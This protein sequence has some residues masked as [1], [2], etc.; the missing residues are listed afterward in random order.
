M[1]QKTNQQQIN[2]KNGQNGQKKRKFMLTLLTSACTSIITTAAFSTSAVASTLQSQLFTIP[3]DAK[4]TE[5]LLDS[6]WKNRENIKNQQTIIDYLQTKPTVP[7]N[8]NIAWKTARLVYFIGNYGVGEKQF[9]DTKAGVA[10][11]DYGV[12]SGKVAMK[13]TPDSPD[14]VEGYYWYAIDL[15]SYGL[16]KGIVASA[17]QAGDGMKALKYAMKHNPTYHWYGSSRVLG[18]YYQELPGIFGG[19][20]SKAEELLLSATKN[21]PKFDNNWIYLGQYYNSEGDYKKGLESCE[22][23][24]ALGDSLD[25]AYEEA[26]YRREANSCV[27]L[28][29]K[30]LD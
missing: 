15:G 8:Y 2:Q 17:W 11:F 13:L 26:R 3:R 12:N 14:S 18:R 5:K 29:K 6:C 21:E 20:S 10:L 19:S 30:K 1:H 25:G 7:N 9:V 16:A 4:L 22:H 28:A 27:T 24:L 23:A